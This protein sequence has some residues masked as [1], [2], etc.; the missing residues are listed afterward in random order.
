MQPKPLPQRPTD[1]PPDNHPTRDLADP[2]IKTREVLLYK[3]AE[4]PAE[5]CYGNKI[6][7]RLQ[8][9]YDVSVTAVYNNLEALAE[10]GFVTIEPR[11][12]RRKIVRLTPT[13]I[14]YLTADTEWRHHQLAK[15]AS[16]HIEP[17]SEP[18][19]ESEGS[20]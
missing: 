11:N 19:P 3:L 1:D 4:L 17:Q 9:D 20:E 16:H 8:D 18:Q 15:L 10:R 2:G 7:A 6:A 12:E 14:E 5:D 13:A